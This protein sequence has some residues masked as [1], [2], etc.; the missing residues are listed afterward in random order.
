VKTPSK[1]TE[2]LLNQIL[3]ATIAIRSN[4]SDPNLP[5]KPS[6]RL[7]KEDS[8]EDDFWKIFGP[9]PQT[10]HDA[11]QNQRACEVVSTYSSQ[12]GQRGSFTTPLLHKFSLVGRRLLQALHIKIFTVFGT[13]KFHKAFHTTLPL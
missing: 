10:S 12:H 6:K 13:F 9:Q 5:R 3:R 8:I 4:S 2:F 11:G 1:T 7:R